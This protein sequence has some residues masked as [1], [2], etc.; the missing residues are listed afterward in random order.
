M[1]LMPAYLFVC[2]CLGAC[3]A[4]AAH[5]EEKTV[6]QYRMDELA[7]AF[8]AAHAAFDIVQDQHHIAKL[9]KA[10]KLAKEVHAEVHD[11]DGKAR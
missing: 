2:L 10:E 8:E 11:K 5:G 9:K 3:G 4:H 1:R 7:K 6:L